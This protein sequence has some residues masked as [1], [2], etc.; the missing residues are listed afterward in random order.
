MRKIFLLGDSLQNVRRFFSNPYQRVF[1]G[2]VG[3]STGSVI[4]LGLLQR[5]FF[6]WRYLAYGICISLVFIFLS[7][8]LNQR[9]LFP[10][11]RSLPKKIRVFVLIFSVLFAGILLLNTEI[12][13][14]YYIL[15][16]MTLEIDFSIAELGPS[17]E[18]V[19][20]LWVETG[21]G[22]VHYSK[23]NIDGDW[24]RSFG[25]TIFS[26]DQKVSITWQ[27]KVGSKSEIAFQSTT[28]DQEVNVTWNGKESTYP[29]NNPDSP[30]VYIQDH[31]EIPLIYKL[32]FIIAFL[33]SISY[34]LVLLLLMLA[35]WHP[36]A[37]KSQIPKSRF[38]W[39]LFMIP[40]LVVWIFS[41]LVFWPGII[42]NDS[43]FQWQQ[44]V[45]GELDD[46][47]SAFHA[48]LLAGL[49]RIWYSPAVVSIL[50]IVLFALAVA[51]GL[52]VLADYGAPR[53]L[54]WIMS[55]LFACFPPNWILSITIWKDVPYAIAFLW[56]TILLIKIVLSEGDWINKPYHW[57]VLATAVF[58]VSI[59]RKN[60]IVSAFISVLTL[61]LVYRRYWKKFFTAT[62]I[63]LLLFLGVGGP[64]YDL[65]NVSR[66]DSGQTNLI[67]LHHIAAH[68]S[69][70]TPLRDE[71]S[72]YLNQ[73]LPLS[74]WFY[75]CCYVGTVSYDG[76]F[77]RNE[78]LT[79]T[80]LN[81][82]IA[83]NLFT[84]A[85]WVDFTHA[86][87]SGELSWRFANNQ[88]YMKSTHGFNSWVPGQVDWVVENEVG[89]NDQSLIPGVVDQYV[90][91]L[92]RFG[93]L[94]DEL[95]FY[96]RPAFWLY[97]ALLCIAV[98]TIR[99]KDFYIWISG[100][101][102]ITQSAVLLLVS[103]APAYRYHYGTCLAGIFL[104]GLLLLPNKVNISGPKKGG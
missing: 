104:L 9:F 19:R 48:L 75:W 96:L 68:I 26:P 42:S 16:D 70:G 98:L 32:P 80:E 73:L 45:S 59:L 4:Y 74:D 91:L 37:R 20:L 55:F 71:E 89:L 35:N 84:R 40:M 72:A 90:L 7:A 31:F 81:R 86:A 101:P 13:P 58:F 41:L 21:Q 87:C 11:I 30:N 54:L 66:T 51:W 64:L 17:E 5:H 43:I 93:F 29:L 28:F 79:N 69:E 23:M 83:F 22:F 56:L 100:L 27:G 77:A 67:Y 102:L 62:L 50:Q 10:R 1:A 2:L 78:F 85:P 25:N 15:P 49:M 6:S 46:W 3:I 61:V 94:D 39:L 8:W 97:I 52:K 88:C 34:G 33:I 99:R 82:Q 92:R 38:S 24:E 53:P 60:G 63:A 103:F 65:L 14:L 95:A 18:G 76:A 44:G 36:I 12:Q 57:M 47:Q